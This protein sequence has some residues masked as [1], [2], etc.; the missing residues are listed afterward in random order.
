MARYICEGCAD[1]MISEQQWKNQNGMCDVCF[2]KYL[3]KSIP[4]IKKAA[5]KKK[6]IERL[7]KIK[8]K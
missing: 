1:V 7:Q 8:S 5:K 6:F 3:N 2:E 4:H